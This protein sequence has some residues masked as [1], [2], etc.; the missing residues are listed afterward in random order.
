MSDTVIDTPRLEIRGGAGAY[1][2]AAVAAVIDRA[3]EEEAESRA[4]R[5]APHVPPAWV[6][7]GRATTVTR[8]VRPVLPDPGINWPD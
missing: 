7:L 8:F 2:A 4:R 3:L 1:E 6:R 5:P